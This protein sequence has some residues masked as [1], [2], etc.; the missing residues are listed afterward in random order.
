MAQME[1]VTENWRLR[2]EL[3]LVLHE[4]L[5]DISQRKGPANEDLFEMQGHGEGG[6]AAIQ[7]DAEEREERLE[8]CREAAW[9]TVRSI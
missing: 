3:N 2:R 4:V 7:L 1:Q 9:A 6:Q 5:G 8:M